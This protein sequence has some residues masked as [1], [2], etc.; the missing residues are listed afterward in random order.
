MTFKLQKISHSVT[1]IR[2]S[3]FHFV[4]FGMTTYT[5]EGKSSVTTVPNVL[6][7]QIKAV[8]P[9]VRRNLIIFFT[10]FLLSQ[11]NLL[12]QK[13]APQKPVKGKSPQNISAGCLPGSFKEFVDLNNVKAAIGTNGA[14]WNLGEPS[15]EVPKGSGKHSIGTGGIW[16]AGVDV[17]GQLRVAA[18]ITG[19]RGDDF[20][21]G[22]L[23][24][25]GQNMGTVS[26]EMCGVYDRIWKVNRDMVTE[27]INWH[28]ADYETRE[29]EFPNYQIPV[30][31]LTESKPLLPG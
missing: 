24:S 10:I 3:S 4:P 23:I 30:V 7:C 22:P 9:T 16:I 29:R 19:S 26:S 31:F 14:L 15:Y 20:W 2:V 8:I 21:P 18:T 27:F 28:K 13:F 12:S 11:S 6:S 25:Q 1:N 17:T 5:G